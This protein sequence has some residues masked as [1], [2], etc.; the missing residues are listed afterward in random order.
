M[1]WGIFLQFFLKNINTYLTMELHE[2]F[3]IVAAWGFK[4]NSWTKSMPSV[5]PFDTNNTLSK[6]RHEIYFHDW[7]QDRERPQ[8][9]ITTHHVSFLSMALFVLWGHISWFTFL[10]F[11]HMIWNHGGSTWLPVAIIHIP[12]ITVVFVLNDFKHI[13]SLNFIIQTIDWISNK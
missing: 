4:P 8:F 12:I 13:K 10:I 11:Y 6:G 3:I 1:F 7:T 5:M 2:L 9:M